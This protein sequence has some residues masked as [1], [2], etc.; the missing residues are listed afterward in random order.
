[1]RMLPSAAI[2]LVMIL[3]LAAISGDAK[4][5]IEMPG[6]D[7]FETTQ[8][9]QIEGANAEAQRELAADPA[10]A[11]SDAA[12]ADTAAP[13]PAPREVVTI[14]KNVSGVPGDEKFEATLT[15]WTERQNE[16]VNSALARD[17]TGLGKLR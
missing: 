14:D 5:P 15:A 9:Q 7:A 16:E 11:Q 1:M 2:A 8:N 10:L 13:D 4:M 12:A 3:G 17:P 6:G